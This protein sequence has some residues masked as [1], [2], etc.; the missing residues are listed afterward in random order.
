MQVFI[1][2]PEASCTHRDTL[3][4]LLFLALSS[5]P[6]HV[7]LS[8]LALLFLLQL[9]PSLALRSAQATAANQ[10]QHMLG[11]SY[12]HT[13]LAFFDLF[14]SFL[15]SSFPV[16]PSLLPSFYVMESLDINQ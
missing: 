6:S 2:Y 7:P 10:S 15:P 11:V 12:I 13:S 9:T 4:L 8:H 16:F 3:L 5:H 1:L 14:W